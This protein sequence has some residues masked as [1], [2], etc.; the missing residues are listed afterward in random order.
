[1][2]ELAVLKN[3]VDRYVLFEHLEEVE[4]MSLEKLGYFKKVL[5]MSDYLGSFKSWIR[6]PEPLVF[7]CLAQNLVIGWAMFERWEKTDKDRTPIF[8][9]RMI[10]VAAK[11]RRKHIGRHL[12]ALVM[13]AAPGH[14]VTR[15]LSQMSAAFFKKLGFIEPP[16]GLSIDLQDKY[17]YLLL[18]TVPKFRFVEDHSS[19]GLTKNTEN[20][21]HCS[22]GLKTQV[23]RQEI[24]KSPGFAHAFTRVLTNPQQGSKGVWS[25][26]N[27][28]FI[29]V[30]MARVACTC[31]S[32]DIGFFSITNGDQK[33]TSVECQ[34]CGKVWLTVPI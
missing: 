24:A 25:T 11:Y 31:G 21:K 18:P 6:R 32:F 9:L 13:E 20:I 26:E 27:K 30:D 17:G 23:L 15:P 4:H 19:R 28:A 29:K 12:M 14:L 3:E 1:M 34:R 5:G 16:P 33:Y 8:V 10:E 2:L 22:D 7:G